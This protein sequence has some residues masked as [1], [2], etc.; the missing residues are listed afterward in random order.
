MSV[1]GKIKKGILNQSGTFKH[2]EN[3]NKRLNESVKELNKKNKELNSKNK[4]LN[5]EKK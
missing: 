2:Y 5:K 1:S 4:K 3:E